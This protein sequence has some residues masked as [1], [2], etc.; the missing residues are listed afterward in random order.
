VPKLR[1][2]GK[3]LGKGKP[4]I[5]QQSKRELYRDTGETHD[6]E[7]IIDLEN[8]IYK[9]VIKDSKTGKIIRECCEPLDKHVGHGYA[10]YKSK[11]D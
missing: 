7:R 3:R 10:K 1:A 2:R 6:V 4:F 8:N 11:K 5:D 9:E